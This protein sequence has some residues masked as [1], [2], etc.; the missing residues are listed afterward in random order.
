M[1]WNGSGVFSRL[2]SWVTDAGNNLD[3]SPSRMDT[4]S[5]DIA[6]ALNNCLTR[7]GQGKPL[8]NLSMNGWK[9]QSMA[10]AATA[11]DALTFLQLFSQG[12]PTTMA[13]A[14]L[15]DIGSQTSVA[16]EISGTTAITSFGTNYNGPRFLRFTGITVLTQSAALNLPTGASITTAVGDTCIAYPNQ[17]LSGWNVVSYTRANGVALGDLNQTAEISVASAATTA[18]GGAASANI[19]ITGTTAITA[20][21]TVAAGVVRH[22]RFAGA[23]TL[24]YNATSMILPGSANITTAANDCAE[25]ESLGGGNWICRA[26]DL[27][28]GGALVSSAQI[29]PL[30][31]PTLASNA[32]TIPSATYNLAFRSATLGAGGSTTITGAPAA[33]TIPSGATLG[34]VS[35]QQSSIAVVAMNNGGTIEYAVVNLAGGNDL[36][37]TGLIST[38]AISSSATANNVFYSNT[39]RTS[40]PY[41]VVG[42]INSTQATAGIWATA[43][44]QV[45]G[46]GGNAAQSIPTASIVR[47]YFPNGY[48]STNTKI[49]RFSSVANAQGPDITYADSATLGGSFTVNNP[50][51]YSMTLFASG[52][53]GMHLGISRNTTQ[54]TVDI[55]ALTNALEAVATASV[56]LVNYQATASQVMPLN[57]GDVIRVHT[58]AQALNTNNFVQ[59]QMT[60]I[61]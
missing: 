9:M 29:Q 4:D 26:Y 40:L 12:E 43:P 60:R 50:G 22:V 18:I 10:N 24:T 21:D 39:A 20:F 25:F 19:L 56:P 49:A 5:N 38:T 31:T 23:L 51:I 61:R 52:P 28:S 44:T 55:F 54:P 27:A 16:V 48:G 30:P 3:I 17:A 57:A 36:S 46:I 42:L 33:L 45:Q 13:S 41:R 34:S 47:V 2:Y 53:A 15:V 32:L 8:A 6:S 37:E 11:G 58:D 7:D 14:A 35:G 59:F 1:P